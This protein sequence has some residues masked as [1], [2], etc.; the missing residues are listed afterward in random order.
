MVVTYTTEHL[1]AM[2]Q[3]LFEEVKPHEPEKFITQLQDA[4]NLV[5]ASVVETSLQ[6]NQS[7]LNHLIAMTPYA[8]KAKA[9]RRQALE[10][11]P[12]FDVTAQH[13][14]YLFQKK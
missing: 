10:Q 2:R 12:Q 1:L 7:D 8:Y 3:A 9:E 5:D 4:F 11:Q 14:I 6:L 13:Q